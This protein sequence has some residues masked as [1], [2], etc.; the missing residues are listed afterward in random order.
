MR[1]CVGFAFWRNKVLLL[2]KKKGPSYVVGKLNG[3]GG[4][5]DGNETVFR[6]MAREFLEETGVE[7]YD[8]DWEFF[9]TMSG[10]SDDGKNFELNCFYIYLS[11][12]IDY[13]NVKN[14]EPSGEELQWVD[15]DKLNESTIV[16]NLKWLVPLALDITTPRLTIHEA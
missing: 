12:L 2:L 8:Y 15:I 11:D 16:E 9:A 14:P 1:Y 13:E 6:A 4:K 10:E 7:T 5:I 3:V